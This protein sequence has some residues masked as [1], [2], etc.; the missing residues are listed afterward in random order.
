M[1]EEK[2][3]ASEGKPQKKPTP[4]QKSSIKKPQRERI[5]SEDQKKPV[6]TEAPLSLLQKIDDI[7]EEIEK[8]P[9]KSYDKKDQD[10]LLKSYERLILK[11][12]REINNSR[13]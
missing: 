9:L 11:M 1:N 13:R 3:M 10:K 7:V 4:S 2:N 6:E 5:K 12:V 8:K